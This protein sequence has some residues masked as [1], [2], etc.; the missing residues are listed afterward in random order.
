M[1]PRG[2]RARWA[3]AVAAV[4]LLASAPSLSNS[5]AQDDLPLILRNPRLHTLTHVGHRFL[6]PY[7]P[8]E[9]GAALYRPLSMVW[10]SMEWW[11]G[12]GSP[13]VFHAVNV[14]L[15]AG[16]AVAV[17]VLLRML[18]PPLAA[19]LGGLLF[20][21]H[22]VHVEAVGNIVGQSELW[23]AL[24][25]VM[26][27]ALYMRARR[28]GAPSVRV[29]V[30]IVGLYAA[31]ALTKEQGLML[32]AFLVAAELVLPLTS[33]RS[34]PRN[35]WSGYFAL[36]SIALGFVVVR[37]LVLGNVVGEIA[38]TAIR[39]AGPGPRLLTMLGVVPQWVRLLL[40]PAHL[41]ADYLP[42]ELDLAD[43]F[44]PAQLLGLGLLA[45]LVVLTWR[46]RR[47]APAVTFG[48]LWVGI[49]L[50]P[51]SNLVVSTGILLAER[52]LLLPS[53]GAVIAV[54]A[55]GAWLVAR[56]PRVSPRERAVGLACLGVLVAVATLASA[57]RQGVWRDND[58][59]YAQTV[60]D[61]P[62][63]Y[64][65][66]WAWGSILFQ[67]GDRRGAEQEYRT[68]LSLYDRDPNLLVDLADRYLEGGFCQPAISLYRRALRAAPVMWKARS[69][70]TICLLTVDSFSAART[71]AL[72][73][74]SRHD[75]DAARLKRIVD[76]AIS[77]APRRP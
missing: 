24:W 20:A 71:E 52:T 73:E 72:I 48:L 74:A 44:G 22:P 8:P 41:Q 26:A 75:P 51:V 59:L 58:S 65:A 38:E 39:H 33:A 60:Q 15:Y 12:G 19:G 31:A 11:A 16:L 69:N 7:W 67:R 50:F 10:F 23:V 54:V 29:W 53:V 40:V 37:L 34:E 62:L 2:A 32:P 35:L 55:G 9:I 13:F 47:E 25:M 66:H 27:V 4:A 70:L 17:Y 45:G 56:L 5:F 30:G 21:A 28:T 14:A 1:T 49:A 77:A 57:R 6:E 63:S 76:S 68:A 3:A 36:L 61:A 18:L 42:R 43:G 64:K 46:A